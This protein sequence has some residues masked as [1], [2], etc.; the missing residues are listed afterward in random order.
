MADTKLCRKCK[1]YKPTTEFSPRPKT[2][3]KDGLYSWCKSCMREATASWRKAAP[4]K[5]GSSTEQVRQWRRDNPDAD[6]KQRKKRYTAYREEA[7]HHYGGVIPKCACCEESH[8]EF[9]AL[10]H[11]EGGGNIH[12]KETGKGFAFYL[13]LRKNG[14][15]PLFRILCHNCNSSMGYYGYC[16][17]Q[18]AK[19]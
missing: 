18:K 14:Y 13:W 8:K 10:D 16:P 7:L 6:S 1:D 15:P 12:R 3:A 2:N 19:E 4:K 11:I 9:L 17:H 5:E